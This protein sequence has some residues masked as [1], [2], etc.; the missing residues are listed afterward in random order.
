MIKDNPQPV[1]LP[2]HCLG[3]KPV[4]DIIEGE[5]VKFDRLLIGQSD[6]KQIKLK[7]NGFIPCKWRLAGIEELP[8]EFELLNTSGELNPTEE[9]IVEISFKA[10][11]Q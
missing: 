7:N 5:P 6:T 8:K 2:V 9:T 11:E 1:I 3:A 4:V 10:I